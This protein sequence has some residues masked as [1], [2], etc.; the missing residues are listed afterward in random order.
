M[1]SQSNVPASYFSA[2]KH[3]ASLLQENILKYL[4]FVLICC[5][6]CINENKHMFRMHQE[7]AVQCCLL[8]EGKV[9]IC[10]FFFFVI[11]NSINI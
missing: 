9:P 2:T 6:V 7:P 10:V 1:Q 5:K 3:L 8:K 11:F 4:Y